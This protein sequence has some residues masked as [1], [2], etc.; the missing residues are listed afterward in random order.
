MIDVRD[1][2]YSRLRDLVPEMADYITKNSS[3]YPVVQVYVPHNHLCA[4]SSRAIEYGLISAGHE[5]REATSTT[6]SGLYFSI[7][8]SPLSL[9]AIRGRGINRLYLPHDEGLTKRQQVEWKEIDI[10]MRGFL[11][12]N[13]TFKGIVY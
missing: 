3:W 8:I 10:A 2:A 7:C 13:K 6:V 1:E 5:I 11:R 9:N 12:A 4:M